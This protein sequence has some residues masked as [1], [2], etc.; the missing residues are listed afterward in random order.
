M[1]DHERYQQLQ[2]QMRQMIRE[3]KHNYQIF[4]D[5]WEESNTIL[6]RHGGFPPIPPDDYDAQNMELAEQANME[7]TR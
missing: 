2:T 6:N 4:Q 5:A 7:G 3:G 1:T